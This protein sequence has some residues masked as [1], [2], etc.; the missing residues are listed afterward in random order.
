[1]SAARRV[2]AGVEYAVGEVVE[3]YSQNIL[4][5]I[6]ARVVGANG[7][8]TYK[9]DCKPYAA[10]EKIR[11]PRGGEQRQKHAYASGVSSGCC[12]SS[13]AM[14][15]VPDGAFM[16]GEIVE[17]DS[18]TQGGWIPAKVLAVNSDG[19][20]KLDIKPD[21]VPSKM[22]RQAPSGLFETAM[23]EQPQDVFRTRVPSPPPAPRSASAHRMF[24]GR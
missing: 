7:N 17:Y 2:K 1:M 15:R 8:G 5:W 10:L 21:A 14:A 6:P 22:R 24:W 19:T 20:Y 12:S 3:Y 11:R 4:S 16:P 18:K 9:L 13:G 23:P